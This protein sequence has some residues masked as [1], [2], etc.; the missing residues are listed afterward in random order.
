LIVHILNI[1][2]GTELK[3]GIKLSQIDKTLMIVPLAGISFLCVLFMIMPEQSKFVLTA[4]RTFLGD[5]MGI[6]YI[7]MGVFSLGATMYMA[8]SKFGKIKL[9]NVEKPI[10]NSFAWGT[11]IFTST[12]AA[13]IL[14]YSLCEWALYS[15]EP[16]VTNLG[17]IQIWGPTF[18]LFHWGPIAWSFY[19]VLAVS[20]G[21]MLH[22]RGRTK[23]KFS[24]AC[25]PILGDKVDGYIGKI[26][27]LI[28]IFALLAGTQG[29]RSNGR[30]S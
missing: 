21:F 14:F 16:Y 19:I 10:Y 24:E 8:F 1:A 4:I 13:D 3:I 9:G 15:P 27:D 23:Q 17:G 26:I 25:R 11:M 6:Y 18:P 29:R 5:D 12:M 28:A 30:S 22:I 7:L 20:F 2:G